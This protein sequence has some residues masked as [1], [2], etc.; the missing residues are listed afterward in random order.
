[1]DIKFVKREDIIKEKWNGSV[2]YAPNGNVFGYMWYLDFVAKDW[3]ALIEGD[4]LSVFPL[5]HKKRFLGGKSLYQ[6][7]QMRAMGIYSVKALSALRIKAFFEAIPAEYKS[8][9]ITVNARNR[10]PRDGNYQTTELTNHL[11]ML[12]E[13]YESLAKKYSPAFQEKLELAEDKG[14]LPIGSIKPEKLAAFFQENNVRSAKMEQRFHTLQRIMY[15]VLHRGTGF[16][17]AIAHP[18]TEELLAADF[19][20]FSHGRMM[21]LAPVVSEQGKAL[22]AQELLLDYMLRSN[23]DRPLLLD[24]NTEENYPIAQN[25]GAKTETFYRVKQ[26]RGWF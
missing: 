20:I 5:V 12:K 24:F 26:R 9:D 1:M 3:D 22:G 10:P 8:I 13:P 4:Y 23:A 17:T 7:D 16:A 2:H 18:E 19:F 21:S 11:L 25:M 14:L 15:N 6:P